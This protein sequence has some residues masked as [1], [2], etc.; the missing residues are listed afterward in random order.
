MNNKYKSIITG[1]PTE[2]I[3]HQGFISLVEEE[4][5]PSRQK[6]L[7][8]ILKLDFE[9][10]R[11][12]WQNVAGTIMERV[13]F[14]L[15]YFWASAKGRHELEAYYKNLG[16]YFELLLITCHREKA[17]EAFDEFYRDIFD[18]EKKSKLLKTLPPPPVR[19]KIE[20]G[21]KHEIHRM[22]NERKAA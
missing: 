1:K 13:P 15:R 17:M 11:E 2:G 6:E 18:P 3:K 5:I 16:F 14:S 8:D 7:C 12:G 22:A 4:K 10:C 20:K 9:I 19:R 21:I